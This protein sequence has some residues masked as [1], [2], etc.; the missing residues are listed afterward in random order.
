MMRSAA[1]IMAKRLPNPYIRVIAGGLAII[2]MTYICGTNDYNGVGMEV[3]A[4]AVEG[5]KAEPL[6]F[7]LKMLF[8]A[9]TLAAGFKGG[10]IV[11]AFFAGATFG[12]VAAPFLGIP[13]GFGAAIGLICVFCGV[14]NCP[15]SS[16]FLSIEI[17]GAEGM[18]YFAVACCICYMMSGYNGIYSSQM[19]MYSKRKAKFINAYTN[20]RK[21]GDA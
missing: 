9:I 13:A 5:G 21:N 17:F 16:I 3:I 10:E 20:G 18:L 1:K 15:I 4:N 14:T 2:G 12:C 6:A 8:T 11:P 19:I 7:L